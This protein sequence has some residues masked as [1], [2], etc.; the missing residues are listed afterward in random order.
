VH[1]E[2]PQERIIQLAVESIKKGGIIVYPTDTAY[3]LG[4]QLGDKA[5]LERIRDIR[6]LDAKHHFTLLC[7]DLSEISRY[8]SFDTP[9]YRILKAHT[10]GAYTFLLRATKTVP[11]RLMHPKKKTIG[12][13]IPDNPVCQAL[14]DNLGEPMLTTTLIMPREVTPLQ[15]PV[16]IRDRLAGRA[17]VILDCGYGGNSVTTMVD[18]TA[19]IPVL[20]REG[21]GNKSPFLA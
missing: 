19:G 20:V 17:D 12:L 16:V 10:P 7:R 21:A 11:R 14:L 1:G 6:K 15:D 4:C 2:N 18:L 3:A 8:A 5:A 13:R 9:V